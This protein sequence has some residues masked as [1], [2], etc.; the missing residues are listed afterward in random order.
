MIRE[1][2][3][4]YLIVPAVK[5]DVI[6]AIVFSSGMVEVSP[7]RVRDDKHLEASTDVYRMQD[8]TG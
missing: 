5:A 2:K 8:K 3:K 6:L 1:T 4:M 7:G